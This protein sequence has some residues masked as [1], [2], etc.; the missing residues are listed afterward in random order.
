MP[1]GMESIETRDVVVETG[2][3]ERSLSAHETIWGDGMIVREGVRER[4]VPQA[5][6]SYCVTRVSV[7]HNASVTLHVMR[8][9]DET[10]FGLHTLG[11]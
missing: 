11:C 10:I 5:T 2:E 8:D 1:E 9:I 4:T 3:M 7:H 6:I